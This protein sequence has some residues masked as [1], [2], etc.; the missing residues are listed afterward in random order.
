MARS[1]RPKV[2][3]CL[4][5][6]AGLLSDTNRLAE[7]EQLMRRALEIDEASYA[8]S[9]PDLA[10]RLY[11]LAGFLYRRNRFAEELSLNLGDGRGQA[12]AA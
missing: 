12:A 5:D 3:I 1:A 8:P 7:A 10:L 4:N 6:L 11:N 9:H 2:A